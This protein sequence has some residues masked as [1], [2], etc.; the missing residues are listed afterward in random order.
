M[1]FTFQ[2]ERQMCKQTIALQCDI[3]V[4]AASYKALAAA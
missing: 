3:L 4:V 2:K 1:E